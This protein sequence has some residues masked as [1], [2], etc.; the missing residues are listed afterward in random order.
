M[1]GWEVSKATLVDLQTCEWEKK[2]FLLYT[3]EFWG[4][5]LYTIVCQ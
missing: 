2:C 5:L 3:T 1:S 4:G